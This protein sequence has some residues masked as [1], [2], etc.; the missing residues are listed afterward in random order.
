MKTSNDLNPVPDGEKT[1]EMACACVFALVAAI[2]IIS[3][4][5]MWLAR[6]I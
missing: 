2:I 5:V 6:P 3:I 4:V 1:A